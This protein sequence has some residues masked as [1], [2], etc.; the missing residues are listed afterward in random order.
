MN[1]FSIRNHVDYHEHMKGFI[2][3]EKV[4]T[5]MGKYDQRLRELEK[6]NNALQKNNAKLRKIAD[7]CMPKKPACPL[8]PLE[9]HPDFI[10]LKNQCPS[11]FSKLNQLRKECGKPKCPTCPPCPD[12]P[13]PQSPKCASCPECAHCSGG[14]QPISKHPDYPA[15]AEKHRQEISAAKS[16]VESEMKRKRRTDIRFHPDYPYFKAY[17]ESVIKTAKAGKCP[18]CPTCAERNAQEARKNEIPDF[19]PAMARPQQ[20]QPR[21][22]NVPNVNPGPDART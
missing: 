5:L 20:R 11:T 4:K 19:N 17:Y 3:K 1:E 9:S 13:G 8:V 15:L 21:P 10:K 2:S 14:K 22:G 7:K 6:A 16:K 12:C 18:P